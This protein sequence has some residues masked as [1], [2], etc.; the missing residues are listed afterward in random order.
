MLDCTTE[1][2]WEVEAASL[3]IR[4]SERFVRRFGLPGDSMPFADSTSG[5]IRTTSGR[6]RHLR[7]SMADDSAED[8][9]EVEFRYADAQGNY[10]WLLSRGKVIER[11]EQ[12]RAVRAAGTHVD[13]TRLKPGAGRAAAAP[14]WRPRPP[15]RPRVASCPA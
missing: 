13:I 1:S 10:A 5:S 4:V 12:G 9:F 3:S 2:L 14:A 15:A 11:D 6:V 7:P 8:F